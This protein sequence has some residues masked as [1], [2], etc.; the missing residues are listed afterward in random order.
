MIDTYITTQVRDIRTNTLI[1]REV[2]IKRLESL[3]ASLF[4]R[5]RHTQVT[6]SSIIVLCTYMRGALQDEVFSQGS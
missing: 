5:R 3:P 6:I 1:T 2:A 4:V